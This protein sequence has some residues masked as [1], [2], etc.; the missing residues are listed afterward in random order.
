MIGPERLTARRVIAV[1]GR[2]L[3]GRAQ[4]VEVVHGHAAPFTTASAGRQPR[5]RE[6]VP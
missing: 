4:V 1:S 2:A 5:H 3:L 6:R